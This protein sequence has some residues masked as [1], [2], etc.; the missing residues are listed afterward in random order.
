MPTPP[1]RLRPSAV[2]L[3]ALIARSL[4]AQEPAPAAAPAPPPAAAPSAPKSFVSEHQLQLDGKPFDYTATAGETILRDDDGNEIAAFFTFAYAQKGGDAGA[5]PVTFVYNGGPG[6]SSIWLHLGLVGPKHVRVPSDGT[7]AGAPPYRLEDN[8]T[9][10]LA[11]SDLVLVDPV[12][13]GF[14]RP[15]GKSKGESFWGVDEDRRSVARFI[16]RWLTENR[17]WASPKYLLGESYG[18]IRTALLLRELQDGDSTVAVNGAMLVSPAFDLQFIDVSD[19]DLH[20]ALL[21]P[22]LAA[23]AQYHH[24]LPEEPKDATAFLQQAREFAAGDYLSALFAGTALGKERFEATVAQLH[25]FTGLADDYLRRSHLRLNAARFRREL[26]RARG[27]VVGRLDTRYTGTEAD[28]VGEV[29]SG[30]PMMPA[31][32]GAFT[33]TFEDYCGRELGVKLDRAYEVMSGRAN[34]EWKRSAET[35]HAFAGWLDVLPALV[36]A[37]ADNPHLRL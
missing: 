8:P 15:L 19:S 17:R 14:S 10:L 1:R 37:Q 11:V 4:P 26:L 27:L 24:A 16:R 25:R 9:T 13:T 2:C 35:S 28:D 18:G 32:G 21:L 3:W 22:T 5:R 12:G 29:P 34:G 31:I 23:T 6:S 30:D 7:S 20:A 33:A 36:R